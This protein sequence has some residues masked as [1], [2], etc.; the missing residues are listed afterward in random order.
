MKSKI[1]KLSMFL[2]LFLICSLTY[3]Q[4]NYKLISVNGFNKKAES[5]I[6]LFTDGHIELFINT[7]LVFVDADEKT[8]TDYW[9]SFRE[10]ISKELNI[11]ISQKNKTIFIVKNSTEETA[12]DIK[13]YLETYWK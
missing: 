8:T 3:G 5:E 2:S 6:K 10:S 12:K 11:E 1:L 4:D 13:K 9:N 7:E